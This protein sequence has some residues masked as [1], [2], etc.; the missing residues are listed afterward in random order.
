MCV[1]K[2]F[3]SI[4]SFVMAK[5]EFEEMCDLCIHSLWGIAK[6]IRQFV[7]S[8]LIGK[9]FLCICEFYG[10]FFGEPIV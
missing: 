7:V 9:P 6:V 10:F 3:F 4:I 2:R 8:I 1:A 5:S